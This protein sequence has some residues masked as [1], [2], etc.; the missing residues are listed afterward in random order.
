[1]ELAC[2]PKAQQRVPAMAEP[3]MAQKKGNSYLRLTPK[4][5]GSVTPR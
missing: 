4:I 5:A 3:I 1:M 2:T